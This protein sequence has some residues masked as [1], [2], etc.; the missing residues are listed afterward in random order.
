MLMESY[1]LESFTASQTPEECLKKIYD[2]TYLIY[3]FK[4]YYLCLTENWLDIDS[5]MISGYPEKMRIAVATTSEG[6]LS[7]HTYEESV[8]F[9]TAL[10]IPKLHEDNPEPSV[11]YFSPV[12][13][14]GRLLGYSVIHRDINDTYLLNLVHRNWLRFV[15]NALEM[16]RNKKRLQLLSV[17]DELTGAYNRHGMNTALEKMLSEA[18]E[19]SSLLVFVIDMD[20][21]KY[22]NDTFGHS[23]GDVCIKQLCSAVTGIARD[24]EICVRAGGDEFYLIG[25]G[26]YTQDDADKRIEEFAKLMDSIGRSCEKRYKITASIGAALRRI[27]PDMNVKDI[28]SEADKRMYQCKLE[29]KEQDH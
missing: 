2:N 16:I 4:N 18:D 26:H 14:D 9:D 11:Y 17:R 3:P 7:F 12:H 8:L 19:N 25:A 1:I 23:E 21:L 20:K 10:M 29:R 27:D 24:N 22:I 13:F 15:N 5:D 6:D 28:I